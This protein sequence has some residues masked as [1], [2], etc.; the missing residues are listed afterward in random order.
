M[1]RV[2]RGTARL[3]STAT[4]PYPFSSTALFPPPPTIPTHPRIAVGKGLMEHVNKTL[5][6]PEK[7]AFIEK[8]F[9]ARSK[10][11]LLPGTVLTIYMTYSPTVFSGVIISIRRRGPDTSFVLRNIVQGTGTEVQVFVNSPH[12]K[13]IKVVQRPGTRGTKQTRRAKL[14]YLRSAP[15]KMSLISA[16]VASK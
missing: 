1:L 2:V 13:D 7:L 5:P 6:K 15:D 16:G 10:E 9:S 3:L 8:Y 14:F 4:K 12:L 11:R